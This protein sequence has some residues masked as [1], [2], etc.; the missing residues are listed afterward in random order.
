MVREVEYTP[1]CFSEGVQD[2]LYKGKDESLLDPNSYRGITL[3]SVFK[4]VFKTLVW[5]RLEW[6]WKDAGVLFSL[7]SACKKGL[8]RL[9]A[10]LFAERDCGYIIGGSWHCF[11]CQGFWFCL[12]WWAFV[13]MWE[14]GIRGRTWSLLYRCFLDFWCCARVQGHVLK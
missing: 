12:D 13:Q 2:S 3:L 7:Q 1:K 9:N 10:S 14:A 11:F 4:K 8:C 6:C 5:K